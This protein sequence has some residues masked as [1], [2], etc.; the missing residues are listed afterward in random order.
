MELITCTFICK[1]ETS[2]DNIGVSL[3]MAEIKE[4]SISLK[5]SASITMNII[6]NNFGVRTYHSFIPQV[7]TN[8]SERCSSS[9]TRAIILSLKCLTIFK[10]LSGLNAFMRS[11]KDHVQDLMGLSIYILMVY[12]VIFARIFF[13]INKIICLIIF[14]GP[15]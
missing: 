14:Q 13:V 3:Q 5:V 2:H 8:G 1:E 7:T 4:I 9:S 15:I 6:L 12:L 11:K 10:K